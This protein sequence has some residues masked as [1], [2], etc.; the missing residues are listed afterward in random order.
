MKKNDI[1]KVLE[2]ANSSLSNLTDKQ[3]QQYSSEAHKKQNKQRASKGGTKTLKGKGYTKIQKKG[4]QVAFELGVGIHNKD[5][6]NYK[7]WKSA[8][9]KIGADSQIKKGLGIHTKDDKKRKEWARL[10]GLAVID[11]LNKYKTCPHCKINTRGAAYNR[12][13]G[14]NCKH[15]K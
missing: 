11:K 10:G 5:N 14:D 2:E 9:G 8:A 4:N 1:L 15:K 12:W 13:H 3:I 6:K 7:K